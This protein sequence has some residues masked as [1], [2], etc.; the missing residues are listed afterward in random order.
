MPEE[1]LEEI[2]A[3]R[4][5]RRDLLIGTGNNPYP[6][7][8]RR[9]HTLAEIADQFEPLLA[10]GTPVTVA[11]RVAALRRHGGIVFLDL[12]DS[13]GKL[14]LQINRDDIPADA[15][16][17]LE[18]LDAGDFIQAAGKPILTQRSVQS[19][20]VHEWHII[21]KAI[22]PLPSTWFGLKDHES[23]F[24]QREVDFLLNDLLPRL[25]PGVS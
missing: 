17:R 25:K 3:A 20:A 22:R 19:V 5:A 14:Q 6:A 15:F 9:S 13:A 2:R 10:D 12:K 23:R 18:L 24:R 21:T 7:E 8:V 4:L 1:R 11:G 16:S